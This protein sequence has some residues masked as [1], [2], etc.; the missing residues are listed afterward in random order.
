MTLPS[1]AEKLRADLER[2]DT[3]FRWIDPEARAGVTHALAEG[4]DEFQ[5]ES[6]FQERGQA[7]IARSVPLFHG[8]SRT[9]RLTSE[10]RVS[11]L[12]FDPEAPDKVWLAL[13]PNLP[14]QM[15]V[16]AEPT[17]EGLRRDLGAYLDRPFT[18]SHRLTRSLRI[19]RGALEDL[20]LENID[21]FANVIA[22]GEKWMD[23]AATWKSGC[24]DD[25]WPDDT[26]H[27]SMIQLRVMSDR[28]NE[29]HAQRR[30]SISMRTLWSRS[31]LTIEQGPFDHMVFELRYDDAPKTTQRALDDDRVPD[32]IPVDLLASLLRGSSVMP[33]TFAELKR[34]TLTPFVGLLACLLEPAETSTFE[35]L[36]TMV[37][38]PELREPAL[39]LASSIGARGVLYELECETTDESLRARLAEENTLRPAETNDDDAG[40]YDD[41]D[42]DDDDDFDDEDD[43]D[44]SGYGSDD[45]EETP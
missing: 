19:S 17:V 38:D 2:E 29:H 45:E 12:L 5:F 8:P 31:V 40:E 25:P 13:G 1:Y 43:D 9:V 35:L 32:C 21:H 30:P 36:R 41:E 34:G 3:R 23:G 22:H 37:R 7:R 39:S 18:S 28:A 42:D 26:S 11:T 27:A 20:G 24:T 14:P 33:A 16:E 10:A 6:D 4:F 44:L 15:W